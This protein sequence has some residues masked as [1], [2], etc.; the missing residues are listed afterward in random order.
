MIRLLSFWLA[1]TVSV[2][3]YGQSPDVTYMHNIHG[4]KLF[5]QGNQLGYPIIALNSGDLLE[6]HF[7][8]LDGRVKNYFYTFQLCNADWSPVNLSTFDYLK[9]F[10]EVRLNQYRL[11]SISQT[12]YVH[13]QAILP[14]RNCAPSKSGNYLLKI[15]LDGDTSKLAFTRRLLVYDKQAEVGLSITQPFNAELFKTHQKV[16]FQVNKGQLNVVNPI[17]Q[18]KAVVLQNY[19][20]DN[21]KMNIPP[22]FIRNNMMEF[23][24]ENVL[25]FPAGREFRWADLRS[26][27]LQ[28]E[29][30]DRAEYAPSNIHIYLKPDGERTQARYLKFVDYNGFYYVEST[31][32]SNPWWQSDYANVHFTFVPKGNQPFADK[33]VFVVGEMNKYNLDDTSAMTYNADKGVY[34]KTLYL[35]QGYYSYIYVTKDLHNPNSE[36]LTE[37]TEG[38][39]WE[40]ENEYTVLVYYRSLSGRHDELIGVSNINSLNSRRVGF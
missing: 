16:Q 40:S 11:S 10:S 38:D 30:V 35:K 2:I 14:D 5:M 28:T 17:Q 13:Y 23:N 19:R 36:P 37:Q 22:T 18:I 4:V 21:A 29:R 25:V 6:L 39:Y 27:R 20:W 26:F 24:N 8:D 34:E 7:D 32:V 1:L 12:K 33:K 9:G 15:F 31:E 3:C